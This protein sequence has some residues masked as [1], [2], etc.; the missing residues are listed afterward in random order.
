MR[1]LGGRPYKRPG[2]QR[3]LIC[4]AGGAHTSQREPERSGQSFR[5]SKER[6]GRYAH[7]AISYG[8]SPSVGV[9]SS[10]L[11]RFTPFRIVM[12]TPCTCKVARVYGRESQKF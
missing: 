4:P 2:C 9:L 11:R 1:Q 3:G 12:S 6:I 7:N 8:Q 10:P 5:E